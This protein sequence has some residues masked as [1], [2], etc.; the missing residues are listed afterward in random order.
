MPITKE[1]AQTTYDFIKGRD[2]GTNIE[3]EILGSTL[4]DKKAFGIGGDLGIKYFVPY[5][6]QFKP[7]IGVTLQDVGN[8]RFFAG[9]KLAQIEQSLSAGIALHYDWSFTRNTFAVDFRNML[10][11]QDFENKVHF[12]A[13]SVLWNMLAV[14]AGMSQLYWTA[15][16]GLETKFFEFDLFLTRG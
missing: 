8:T 3:D 14:R 4:L 15:G 7:T 16:L 11:K 12:G 9:D 13:E 2:P 5:F 1:Q 6:T 10:E